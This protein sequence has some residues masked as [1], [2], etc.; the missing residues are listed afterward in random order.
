MKQSQ[1]NDNVLDNNGRPKRMTDSSTTKNKQEY[2]TNI[3]GYSKSRR[4]WR[5][6]YWSIS[7][8]PFKLSEKF[9]RSDLKLPQF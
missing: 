6:I 4:S 5:A 7:H 3:Y 9:C 2:E 1:Y 8:L